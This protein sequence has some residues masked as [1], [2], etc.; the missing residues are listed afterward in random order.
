MEAPIDSGFLNKELG[1]MLIAEDVN[2]Y[3]E[4][5]NAETEA[6]TY[7]KYIG[8]EVCLLNVANEKLMTK[9]RRKIVSNDTN[10]GRSYNLILD[11]ST[12]KVQFSYGTMDK[13]ALNVIAEYMLS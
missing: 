13:L 4:S 5:D 2:E 8:I 11:S 7:N 6:N 1:I 3:V 12:N 9:V 10:N